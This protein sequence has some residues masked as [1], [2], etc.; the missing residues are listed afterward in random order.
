MLIDKNTPC[1]SK[2]A[3][4]LLEL[5]IV[6]FLL[7]LFASSFSH[8]FSSFFEKERFRARAEHFLRDL[9][10]AQDQ[11]LLFDFD[12]SLK[13]FREAQGTFFEWEI[14]FYP[15]ERELQEALLIKKRS[16]KSR[17]SKGLYVFEV[18]SLQNNFSVFFQA[19]G[20]RMPQKNFLL[21]SR[22]NRKGYYC[23]I[24]VTNVLGKRYTLSEISKI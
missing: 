5:L 9:Q 12:S 14:L 23:K 1:I 19:R 15:D 22:E 20:E 17:F 16:R 11:N 13:I 18:G 24:I 10:E 4:S 7:S 8:S 6:F 2:K 3:L 21:F